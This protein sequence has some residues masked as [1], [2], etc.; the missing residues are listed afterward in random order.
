MLSPSKIPKNG[1]QI[2]LP[3]AGSPLANRLPDSLPPQGLEEAPP[4][5]ADAIR[6]DGFDTF[7][8]FAGAVIAVHVAGPAGVFWAGMF[9]V[10]QG[11]VRKTPLVP[12]VVRGVIGLAHLVRGDRQL[13]T[14]LLRTALPILEHEPLV[15]D[16]PPP[17]A[18]PTPSTS[19]RLSPAPPRLNPEQTMR[20]TGAAAPLVRRQSKA[21]YKGLARLGAF[22]DR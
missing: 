22:E 2:P 15:L 18:V 7:S 4:W 1:T 14:S 21:R 20:R 8:L 19:T 11:L 13:L 12:G 5:M 10:A 6:F 16:A 9:F 17:P 3:P